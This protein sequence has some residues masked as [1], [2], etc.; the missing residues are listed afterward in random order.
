MLDTSVHDRRRGERLRDPEFQAAY[1]RAA[2]E[3]AQVD[4]VIRALD[5]LRIDQKMSKA[6]LA[7][8]VA[9]NESS[10]RR[11]FT[12]HQARPE[13]PLLATIAEVLGAQLAVVPVTPEAKRAVKQRG[14][15]EQLIAA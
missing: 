1:E 3:I 7:R 10:I 9:R 4:Q 14:G 2:R 6:E 12:S 15:K 5:A 13:F 8:R 11:L